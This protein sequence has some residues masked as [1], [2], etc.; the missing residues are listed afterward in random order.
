AL[1]KPS[2]FLVNTAR[3]GIVEEVPLAK[4]L[5]EQRLAGAGIDVFATEP[6]SPD[7]PLLGLSSV[8]LSPHM[9]GVTIESTARMARA[10]IGNILSVFDG[11]P[12]RENV[13]NKEVLG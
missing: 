7:N 9:A 12:I 10:A 6:V 1:M 4:A 3:G 8:I 11:R 2:A 5:S 13:V